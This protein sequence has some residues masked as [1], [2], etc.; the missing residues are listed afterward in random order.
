MKK[1]KETVSF[2]RNHVYTRNEDPRNRCFGV[3]GKHPVSMVKHMRPPPLLRL[4]SCHPAVLPDA[5][6][7]DGPEP[8]LAMEARPLL[9]RPLEVGH[10]GQ[11]LAP[12][13]TADRGRAA[14]PPLAGGWPPPGLHSVANGGKRRGIG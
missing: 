10:G 3:G 4:R 6:R 8:R 11:A 12:P 2:L 5:A 1:E 7:D 9:R 14:A 13:P